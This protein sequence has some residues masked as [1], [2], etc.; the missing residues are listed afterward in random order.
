[1]LLFPSLSTIYYHL[2]EQYSSKHCL[3]QQ[4]RILSL[5][6]MPISCRLLP[7]L[8]PLSALF[9]VTHDLHVAKHTGKHS[10]C[11]FLDLL[12]PRN[13]WSLQI[14]PSK[15]FPVVLIC[16]F[17]TVRVTGWATLHRSNSRGHFIFCWLFKSCSFKISLTLRFLVF[18]FWLPRGHNMLRKAALSLLWIANI[19]FPL[20]WFLFSFAGLV[21]FSIDVVIFD[22]YLFAFIVFF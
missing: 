1:M 15:S 6:L 12:Q 16:I 14:I 4:F 13:F 7:L 22:L 9:S 17:L 5:S 19:Y 21:L 2:L 3:H 8:L 11:V 10:V 20:L 18:H